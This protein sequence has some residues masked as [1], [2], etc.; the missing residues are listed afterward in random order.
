VRLGSSGEVRV[1]GNDALDFDEVDALRFQRVHGGDGAFRSGDGDGTGKAQLAVRQ[2]RVQHWPGNNHAR[3]DDFAFSDFLAPG[4]ENRDVS[5]HVAHAGN[6]VG[7]EEGQD[8]VASAGEPVAEGGVHVHVPQA[9]DK[10]LT[11]AVDDARVLRERHGGG[12]RDEGDAISVNHD[13]GVGLHRSGAG[14]DDGHVGDDHLPGF[15]RGLRKGDGSKRERE[16]NQQQD[17]AGWRNHAGET[18]PEV[19]A[20]QNGVAKKLD[21]HRGTE[22]T[23][24]ERNAIRKGGVQRLRYWNCPVLELRLTQ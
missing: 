21:C 15:G 16:R 13:H 12:V 23:V 11:A 5:A 1:V 22:R 8:D 18:T 24:K 6:A 17:V 10:E 19:A 3:A 7:D 20:V 4:E 2:K 14:I 9:G